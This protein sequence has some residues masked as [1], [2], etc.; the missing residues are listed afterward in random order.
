MALVARSF[1]DRGTAP[2][3]PRQS[4]PLHT[5]EDGIGTVSIARPPDRKPKLIE[6][7]LTSLLAE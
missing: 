5:A 3:Q 4:N 6:D 1:N 7:R 2:P